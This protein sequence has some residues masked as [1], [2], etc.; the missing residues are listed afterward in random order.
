MSNPLIR[1]ITKYPLFF[2]ADFIEIILSTDR[3]T[4]VKRL[5]KR[6][7]WGEEGSKQL[8]EE[9]VP[10]IERL[11][12]LM[13]AESKKRENMKILPFV[14]DDIVLTYSTFLSL[15]TS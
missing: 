8:T 2:I 9:D 5:L 14:E 10:R 7:V 3:G 1:E 12:D 13:I 11:Y 6:G 4:A 15:I